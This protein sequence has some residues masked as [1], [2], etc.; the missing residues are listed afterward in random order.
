MIIIRK[1]EQRLSKATSKVSAE[2]TLWKNIYYFH[3]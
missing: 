2:D 1:Q 3:V